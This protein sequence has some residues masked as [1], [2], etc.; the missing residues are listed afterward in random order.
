MPILSPLL[1]IPALINLKIVLTYRDYRNT[2]FCSQSMRGKVWRLM[3]LSN[4][5]VGIDNC[6][7]WQQ[8]EEKKT[9]KLHIQTAMKMKLNF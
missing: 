2:F 8:G 6:N 9:V 3:L 7:N 1:I 5:I 4:L